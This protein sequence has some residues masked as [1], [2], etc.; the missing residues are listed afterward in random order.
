MK[1]VNQEVCGISKGE[2]RTAIKRIKCAKTVGPD[3][4]LVEAWR[5]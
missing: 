4:I 1:I 2:V 5:C 3:D